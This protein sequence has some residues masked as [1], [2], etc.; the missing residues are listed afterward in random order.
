MTRMETRGERL[1]R[2]HGRRNWI[3]TEPPERDGQLDLW[4]SGRYHAPETERAEMPKQETQV[5]VPPMQPAPAESYA[6]FWL[7]VGVVVGI[8]AFAIIGAVSGAF[9]AVGW[10]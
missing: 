9:K 2:N 3:T 1:T 8:V 6:P 10:L 5:E 7:A 4:D